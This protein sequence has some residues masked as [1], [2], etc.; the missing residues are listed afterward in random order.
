MEPIAD[1]QQGQ[2]DREPY[3]TI[4]RLVRET[5]EMLASIDDDEDEEEN[6][7]QVMKRNQLEKRL[8]HLKRCD[9]QH[10]VAERA[11][12]LSRTIG[13]KL[14]GRSAS[15]LPPLIHTSAA[16]YMEWLEKPKFTFKD[17]P[18]F[19]VEETGIPQLRRELLALTAPQNMQ[20]YENH[21]FITAPAVIEKIIRTVRED[22]HEGGFVT[23][24]D[25]F[26]VV[27]QKFM[28]PWKTGVVGVFR[29]SSD[30]S[31]KKLR[32]D[33]PALQN[34]VN[35][36][37]EEWCKLKFAAFNRAMKGKGVLPDGKS[38]AKSPQ[39]GRNLDKELSDILTPGISKWANTHAS[40]M[41]HMEEAFCKAIDQL[42][43][44]V[45]NE[46]D[47]AGGNMVTVEK[48][49]TKWHNDKNSYP[50]KIKTDMM[51]LVTDVQRLTKR[52]SD[53]AI[54]KDGR[55]NNLVG[56]I[57]NEWYDDIHDAAPKLKPPVP[58]R[59][60]K[61]VYEKPGRF[62]FQKNRMKSHFSGSKVQFVEHAFQKLQAKFDRDTE[63]L[64]D[65]HFEIINDILSE[66]A[67][68]L[69]GRK[70]LDYQISEHGRAIRADLK[71]LLPHLQDE[72]H[73]IQS[74][75]PQRVK[76]EDGASP[77][78]FANYADLNVD[79]ATFPE[80]YD[81]V[82]KMKKPAQ[83]PKRSTKRDDDS[84]TKRMRIEQS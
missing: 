74:L 30:K 4:N 20:D 36:K 41:A 46:L 83:A 25:A 44:R 24:A 53:W 78:K 64:V 8:S 72:L 15:T 81:R 31:M 73:Q 13:E 45:I 29:D 39:N 1:N 69:R 19:S 59:K 77:S 28:V 40:F 18:D 63:A 56:S 70:M 76:E 9:K 68:H 66:F 6:F 50:E 48:A 80:I 42:H 55:E 26:E 12:R 2:D 23:I 58:G 82:M 17:Q 84:K 35:M 75:F 10:R 60:Q 16:Q 62:Q 38:Y 47:D 34:R 79:D 32:A 52:A 49:K 37:V 11:Q 54:M 33:I 21:V 5:Q 3:R 14:Q 61:K 43:R 71:E 7:A 67:E 57:T 65:K 51:V 22:I 27:G